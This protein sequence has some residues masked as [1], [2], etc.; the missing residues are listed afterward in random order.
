MAGK[1][2]WIVKSKGW[3]ASMDW[4]KQRLISLYRF[5]K[6]RLFSLYGLGKAKAG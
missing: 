2:V 4:E 5:E 1:S 6:Q 3:S